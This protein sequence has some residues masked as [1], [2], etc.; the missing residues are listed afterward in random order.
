MV[1]RLVFCIDDVSPA[2]GWGYYDEFIER[3]LALIKEFRIKLTLFVVPNLKHPE[4][5]EGPA[6]LRSHPGFLSQFK[7]YEKY[8]EIALHGYHHYKNEIDGREFAD[9]DPAEVRHKIAC[10][11]ETAAAVGLKCKGFKAPGWFFP[12]NQI[13]ELAEKFDWIAVNQVGTE[14]IDWGAATLVPRT[15]PIHEEITKDEDHILLLHINP[16]PNLSNKNALTEENYQKVREFLKGK[17]FD[18]MTVSE[19]VNHKR[20]VK[21][22]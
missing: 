5:A 22:E 7:G 15:T 9:L 12:E 4:L 21:N 1:N 2:K 18:F 19:Y 20:G 10:A 3:A 14:L 13:D 17:E 11:I 16:G 6:D 8:I